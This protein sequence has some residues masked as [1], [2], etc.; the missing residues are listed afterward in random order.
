MATLAGA[1]ESGAAR[2][3]DAATHAT[4]TKDAKQAT[5]RCTRERCR[6]S[7]R[8]PR[9]SAPARM[10]TV[11]ILLFFA[12][13]RRHWRAA[14]NSHWK[15]Q[16]PTAV[17]AARAGATEMPEHRMPASPRTGPPLSGCGPV[18]TGNAQVVPNCTNLKTYASRCAFI[19]LSD[20]QRYAQKRGT[21]FR[22][23][24]VS[25][26]LRSGPERPSRPQN[27]I[28]S[29][30]S[31]CGAGWPPKPPPLRPPPEGPLRKLLPPPKPP[32]S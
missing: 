18:S 25:F 31:S 26:F 7:G 15:N 24:S 21:V 17:C 20:M 1:G 27:G 11:T 23:P 10:G 13:V 6:N 16:F 29:S 30:R 5:R 32:S 9:P 2:A 14:Q 12:H 22:A 3:A 28:S 19:R 4:E 8:A